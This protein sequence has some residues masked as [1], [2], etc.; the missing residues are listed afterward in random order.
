MRISKLITMTLLASTIWANSEME[1]NCEY[2]KVVIEQDAVENEQILNTTL[3]GIGFDEIHEVEIS[4]PQ[5]REIN[6][7]HQD[8]KLYNISDS[9]YKELAQIIM[10]EAGGEDLDGK[11]LVGNVIMN[12]VN[13]DRFPNDIISVVRQVVNGTYQFS[14]VLDS[15]INTVVPTEECYKAIDMILDGYDI[16]HN[17]LYFEACKGETWHSRNLEFLFQHGGHKFYR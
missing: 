15:R 10:A 2:V 6:Y 9:E 14:P 17:A 8:E 13:S 12:R 11:I 7:T 1:C 5:I 3:A 16:S 4:E